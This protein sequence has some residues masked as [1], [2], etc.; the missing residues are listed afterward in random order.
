MFPF[1]W[2][3]LAACTVVPLPDSEIFSKRV[4]LVFL[5]LSSWFGSVLRLRLRCGTQKL[6]FP[7]TPRRHNQ[8]PQNGTPAVVAAFPPDGAEHPLLRLLRASNRTEHGGGICN[9]GMKPFVLRVASCCCIDR[10]EIPTPIRREHPR[11]DT[12]SQ[13]CRRH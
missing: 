5:S 11:S 13:V 12:T 10:H 8:R 2:M 4:F 9:R 1:G 6:F 3:G 7:L